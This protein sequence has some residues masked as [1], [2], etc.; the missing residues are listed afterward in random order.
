M[1]LIFDF[2]LGWF[3]AAVVASSV[4]YLGDS[5]RHNKPEAIN[6]SE[7]IEKLW[8]VPG[9]SILESIQEHPFRW[10]AV[11]ILLLLFFLVIRYRRSIQKYVKQIEDESVLFGGGQLMLRHVP[12][13]EEKERS[14]SPALEPL[15]HTLRLNPEFVKQHEKD[16]NL[17]SIGDYLASL[18][19]ILLED[20]AL[21]HMVPGWIQKELEATVSTVLLTA[22]GRTV[23][24]I[25]LPATV[26][27][28]PVKS[29][30]E[31]LAA[32]LALALPQHEDVKVPPSYEGGIPLSLLTIPVLTV[33][34]KSATTP[35]SEGPSSLDKMKNGEVGYEPSFAGSLP[36]NDKNDGEPTEPLLPNPFCIKK[37][38]ERTIDGMVQLQR[39]KNNTFD[40]DDRSMPP[41]TPVNTRLLPDLYL[42]WG[43]AKC[44]HTQ[45]QILENRLLACLLNRLAHNYTCYNNPGDERHI[46]RV[47]V[48]PAGLSVDNPGDFVK[49]LIKSGHDVQVCPKTTITT[50]GI[51][52]CVKEANGTWT[53]L[54]LACFLATGLQDENSDQG[55]MTCM[56][57]G[58]VNLDIT[59]PLIR[60]CNIQ[61]YIAIEGLCGWHSDHNPDAPWL[62]HVNCCK[63]WRDERAVQAVRL[64]GLLATTSNTLATEL[65]LPYGGYGLVGM[66]NDSAAIIEQAMEGTTNMYPL[67]ANGV[68][69]MIQVRHMRDLR[70]SLENHSSRGFAAEVTDLNS[71]MFAMTQL[72]SD[73]TPTPAT[74]GDSNRRIVH[75]LPP[76]LPF[77]L[78]VDTKAVMEKLKA[79]RDEIVALG[80]SFSI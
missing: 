67:T 62:G 79:E 14:S 36:S 9:T 41:P 46:F 63:P 78:N 76:G 37:H 75:C 28:G 55:A 16:W 31:H 72:G 30:V 68:F 71:L 13:D 3:V 52:L 48:D 42:G 70:S 29:R 47:S 34:N 45:R 7:V 35:S 10:V 11:F 44:T 66:C 38:W 32:R 51:A 54:P 19:P 12:T 64:A 39:Q 21:Q 4:Y 59:G 27:S 57:H 60:Q 40:P 69:S 58:G 77:Q 50:F 2:D 65:E 20:P 6:W 61:H 53:N 80:S 15:I 49:A 18:R 22:L 1:S 26:G 74:A 24:S 33:V 8:N 56:P 43:D 25:L 23:G 73:T 17:A 5:I